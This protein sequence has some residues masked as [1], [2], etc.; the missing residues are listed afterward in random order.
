MTNDARCHNE[1]K[2]SSLRFIGSRET[3]GLIYRN[4][5]TRPGPRE[6]RVTG[7]SAI[8][9]CGTC[10]PLGKFSQVCGAAGC[11]MWQGSCEREEKGEERRWKFLQK[12]NYK[13]VVY[14]TWFNL[15]WAECSLANLC[16]DFE[17]STSCSFCIFAKPI[18]YNLAFPAM[19]SQHVWHVKCQLCN[20]QHAHKN[21]H[22]NRKTAHM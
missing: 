16:P 5:F 17:I 2:S 9:V 14:F 22:T 20:I 15:P 6:W 7:L 19:T 3:V 4:H 13:K 11:S 8:T 1:E 18:S 21:T 12:R 10:E